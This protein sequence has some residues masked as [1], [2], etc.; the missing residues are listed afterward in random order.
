MI[1]TFVALLSNA[2]RAEP[3]AEKATMQPS[4]AFCEGIKYSPTMERTGSS[5][6]TTSASSLTSCLIFFSEKKS[7]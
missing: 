6:D 4:R 3:R 5:D 7:I 2:K 1:S